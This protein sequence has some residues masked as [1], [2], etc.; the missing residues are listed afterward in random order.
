MARNQHWSPQ[1]DPD[2][3][4]GG[5]EALSQDLL[6]RAS[7]AFREPS[8]ASLQAGATLPVAASAH[9]RPAP[10]VQTRTSTEPSSGECQGRRGLGGGGPRA[11]GAGRGPADGGVTL[12]AD[13]RA[14]GVSRC[15]QT[16][17]TLT[18][19]AEQVPGVARTVGTK[20]ER[21]V[22]AER[23]GGQRAGDGNDP[24]KRPSPRAG[25]LGVRMRTVSTGGVVPRRSVHPEAQRDRV[26]EKGL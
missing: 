24:G 20:P 25:C 19:A 12:A 23:A 26:W 22:S 7:E 1:P 3:P 17:C 14:S 11:V 2:P 6:G 9:G 21:V 10:Y 13:G 16:Q 18:G 5:E 15:R 8:T 4:G